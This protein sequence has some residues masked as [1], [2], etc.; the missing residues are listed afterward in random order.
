MSKI[1]GQTAEHWIKQLELNPHPEGGYYREIFRSDHKVIRENE[2]KQT[3]ACT[4]IY[5]L[6]EGK[7][8]SGFHRL[9]SDELW[10]FHKGETIFIHVIDQSGAYN[11]IELG[12]SGSG[13][14]QA[15]VE[16]KCW[17]AAEIPSNSGFALVSCAVAPG[18]N[19]SEFEMAVKAVL[20]NS[21]PDLK[22]IINRLCRG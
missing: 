10:Y 19:F 16:A 17:F 18:F 6:L 4:S 22:G 2:R 8:F 14:L 1:E 20:L 21:F 7:D 3:D 9:E 5:Y 11:C 15:V 12:D 13:Q